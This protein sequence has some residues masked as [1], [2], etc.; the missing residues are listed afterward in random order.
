MGISTAELWLAALPGLIAL[1]TAIAGYGAL[2]EKVR[3]MESDLRD[4]MHDLRS[5]VERLSDELKQT[6]RERSR[7][8]GEHMELIREVSA[9]LAR[10]SAL[11]NNR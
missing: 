9:Q 1:A 6:D 3:R 2:R 5:A 7:V 8:C 10:V 11:V 4:L